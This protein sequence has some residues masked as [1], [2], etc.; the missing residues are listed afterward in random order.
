MIKK[1]TIC[2][3]DKD[4]N[5]F[6][7][8]KRKRD[9]LTSQCKVCHKEKQTLWNENNKE[10][11]KN[12]YR[13]NK[14]KELKRSK[15]WKLDNREKN[16]KYLIFY[17]INRRNTDPV[18]KMVDNLRKRINKAIER[19][20][21]SEGTI[22]LLGCNGIFLK[23]YLESQFVNG[24]FWDNYGQWHVDHIRPCNSF[25]LSKPEEQKKCFHYS[26]LQPLWAIDN[27]KKSGRVE[28]A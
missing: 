19:N 8:D 21:K 26:N 1:C 22:K 18:F 23:S 28:G 3:K 5:E 17:A 12:Y 6:Y 27:L 15:K 24:M 11:R 25:D 10:Y 2:K 20:S 4:F 14:E 9:G 16:L 13:N 7:K